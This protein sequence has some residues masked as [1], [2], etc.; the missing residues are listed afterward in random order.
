MAGK[1]VGEHAVGTSPALEN[2]EGGPMTKVVGNNV[3]RIRRAKNMTLEQVALAAGTD[4][5]NLSRLERGLQGYTD[6]GLRAI[7]KVLGVQVAEFFADPAVVRTGE[8]RGIY[9]AAV[10]RPDTYAVPMFDTFASM[11][12]GMQQPDRDTIVNQL[13]INATWIRTHLPDITGPQNLTFITGYGDSM[14]ATFKHGD[15]LFVDRGVLDIKLDAVYVFAMNEEL[16]IKRLQRLPTGTMKV[17]SD[18]KKYESY[19]LDATERA[20]LHVLGRVVGAWNW[21]RL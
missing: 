3:R 12:G 18:N 19:V 20:E 16:F 17:I 21:Q 13:Q 8:D 10:K 4:T 5:G 11:G 1:L 9:E 14:E 2:R 7:A 15:V 6:D